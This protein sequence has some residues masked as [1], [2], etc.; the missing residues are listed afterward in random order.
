MEA[1]NEEDI[2]KMHYYVREFNQLL[3]LGDTLYRSN[4]YIIE[5]VKTRE[6]ITFSAEE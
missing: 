4:M 1:G 3:I 2:N 6:N 5:F